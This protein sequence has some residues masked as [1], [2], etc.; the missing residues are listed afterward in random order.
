M[1][2]S[3]F[4]ESICSLSS[5]QKKAFSE[6]ISSAYFNKNKTLTK[7]ANEIILESQKPTSKISDKQVFWS[8]LFPS[9]KWN[10]QSL[11][12]MLSDLMRLLENFL[13]H[14]SLSEDQKTRLVLD[15]MNKH[16]MHKPFSR[17]YKRTQKLK[18]NAAYLNTSQL[19]E[20]VRTQEIVDHHHFLQG[21]R[22]YTE[23]IQSK[24]DHL[25]WFYMLQKL[26]CCCEMLNRMTVLKSEYNII[27]LEESLRQLENNWSFYE[28]NHLIVIYYQVIQTFLHSD[29]EQAFQTL[30]KY[31][32]QYISD[33]S[34]DQGVAV[35][36]FARNYCTRQ[37]NV[38]KTEYLSE[39]FLLYK[40]S[41]THG[42]LL[43]NGLIS[44]FVYKNIVTAACRLGEF[45]WAKIFIETYKKHL[46]KDIQE[47]AYNYNLATY[48]YSQKMYDK[49]IVLL[50]G[51]QY[52][53][54]YYSTD[55]RV[56]L[57]KMYYDLEEDVALLSLCN[58]FKA[59]IL[60]D[61]K[62]SVY[63]SK[64]YQNLIRFTKKLFLLKEQ[65]NYLKT[66]LFEHKKARLS[67]QI[68]SANI[69]NKQWV[70]KKWEM[71]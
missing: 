61:K 60:R 25:E 32:Q 65:K 21:K 47:N 8:R 19:Y 66:E 39:I 6:F 31:L 5:S 9:K 28:K 26:E 42:Y 18:K 50:Q 71:L 45:D 17:Y 48:Y 16:K 63:Q 52:T 35:L 1:K 11:K 3:L 15:G 4:S 38:G 62:L 22:N 12:D 46:E 58:S 24:L 59:F 56:M 51:I 2:N 40:M 34:K 49:A 69:A 68:N 14:Q 67:K 41:L 37:L 29:H 70:L 54:V 33:L 53:D 57:L 44:Q 10:E 27:S 43:D 7:V 13:A 36:T 23:A 55:A 30:K 20:G 64:S